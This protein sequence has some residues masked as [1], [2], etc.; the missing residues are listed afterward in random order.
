MGIQI[1]QTKYSVEFGID[2]ESCMRH[3]LSDVLKI[4]VEISSQMKSS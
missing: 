1:K 3:W 4:Y 2:L